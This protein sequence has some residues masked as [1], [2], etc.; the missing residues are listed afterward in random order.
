M[1]TNTVGK[2]SP[3]YDE[4]TL[5]DYFS[6][7]Y[8]KFLLVMDESHIGVPQI[9]GMYLGDRA[10]KKT[11][12]EHGFR[13]PS[14]LDNRPLKEEEFWPRIK[15]AIYTSATPGNWEA[16]HSEQL[17]EQIIRPTGLID[18]ELVVKPVDGQV[19]DLLERVKKRVQKKE[20]VLVTTLTKKMSE[21]LADYLKEHGVK[22]KFLHSDVKTLERVWILEELRR[23]EFDCLVGVNLLREGLDL[24]EVSLVAILDADKEGFLRSR[25][26]LVQTIGRAARH[27]RGQVLLYADDMTGSLDF[28]IKETNRRRKLQLAYNKKHHITPK[29]ISKKI[30][31]FQTYC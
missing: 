29:S 15:Q 17:V 18:P 21:D 28:A 30:K 5:I 1:C 4:H 10:R 6:L 31:S 26:S 19:D 7:A 11:L 25:T 14:A 22:A 23:G 2:N 16:E 3:F 9:R 13:L 24:P 27:I 8:D 12:V 20:R